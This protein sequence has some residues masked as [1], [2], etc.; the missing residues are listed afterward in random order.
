VRE[1]IAAFQKRTGLRYAPSEPLRVLGRPLG[2]RE[3]C[4]T[5]FR[6]P[7]PEGLRDFLHGMLRRLAPT[8]RAG[9]WLSS[10]A[11]ARNAQPR[12]VSLFGSLA[13]LE[14]LRLSPCAAAEKGMYLGAN[15]PLRG[16]P[17]VVW[18]SPSLV[19]ARI[20]W[21]R[22][23]DLEDIARRAGYEAERAVVLDSLN[24]YL[25]ELG[26]LGRAGAPGPEKPWGSLGERQR[27]ATLD[28]YGVRPSWTAA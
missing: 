14:P 15:V 18:I 27:R 5:L 17:G 4:P 8:S 2:P 24:R 12:A 3:A 23:R 7:G 21:D 20:R 26:A 1:T 13:V 19:E 28:R 10:D 9:V 6:Y 22:L 11:R 25:E 16:L